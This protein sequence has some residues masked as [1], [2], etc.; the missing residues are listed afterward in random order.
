MYLFTTKII[1]QCIGIFFS[2]KAWVD[3]MTMG[4][5]IKLNKFTKDETLVALTKGTIVVVLKRMKSNALV[6]LSL[7]VGDIFAKLINSLGE[8]CLNKCL[9]YCELCKTNF[10]SSFFFINWLKKNPEYLELQF[11]LAQFISACNS[12]F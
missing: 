8:N 5:I 12:H 10:K 1:Q 6:A 11:L 2:D 9:N 3:L 4:N 7:C